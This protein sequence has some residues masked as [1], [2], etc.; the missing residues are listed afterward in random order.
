MV[1]ECKELFARRR[2]EMGFPYLVVF[3]LLR[4]YL[5][6]LHVSQNVADS[7]TGPLIACSTG[8]SYFRIWGFG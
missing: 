4:A 1:H 8:D 6:C 7:K 2:S 5:Y 3:Q